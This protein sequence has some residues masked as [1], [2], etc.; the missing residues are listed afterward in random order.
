MSPGKRKKLLFPLFF[1]LYTEKVYDLL[2]LHSFYSPEGVYLEGISAL[3]HSQEYSLP[4][5]ARR[6]VWF[7][8]Y[9]LQ[10]LQ[11]A[12]AYWGLVQTPQR[13]AT[14]AL[15]LEPAGLSPVSTPRLPLLPAALL[16]D[17]A[18]P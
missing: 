7:N 11:K 5:T 10:C 16:W 8:M 1:P 4:P 9:S 12:Q 15:L 3:V 14:S 13:W 17:A 6:E 2:L 18:G